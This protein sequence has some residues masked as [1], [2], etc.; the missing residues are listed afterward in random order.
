M[1]A[2][3]YNAIKGVT[4]GAA[5]TGAY[6]PS[7]NASGYRA[8][9]NVPTGWIGLVRFDDGTAWEET[10]SYWNGTTLSRASTQVLASS[11]GSQL[12]LTSAATATL[13]VDAKEVAPHVGGTNW[14]VWKAVSGSVGAVTSVGIAAPTVTGTAAA[15][16]LAATNYLT[17]QVREQLTSATTAAAQAG[18]S[19]A[20]SV[21]LAI[22][23]TAAGRGGWE[24]VSRFGASVLPTGPR[25]FCGMANSSFVGNASDPSA[26]VADFSAFTQDVADTSIQFTVNS[27]VG[28]G[29]KISTGIPWVATGWYEASLWCEPGSNTMYALLIRLDTGAIW[30]GSTTTD[31]PRNGIAVFPQLLGSLGTTTGT[32]I[33]MQMGS[34]AIR[35][36]Q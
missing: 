2:P 25:L 29:T 17:E 6:T 34:V 13:I 30:F 32:A 27:G 16:T 21:A 5:G 14:S 11:T 23:S 10:Y 9:S 3:F 20:G 7:A 31:V 18:W 28:G 22:V 19:T 8:W 24:M 36:G 4:A 15:G 12:T 33:V 1:A 26:F 35:N